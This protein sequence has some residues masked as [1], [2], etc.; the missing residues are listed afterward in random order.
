MKAKYLI[1]MLLIF[2]VSFAITASVNAKTIKVSG[3]ISKIDGKRAFIRYGKKWRKLRVNNKIYNGVEIKTG[4]N[5]RVIIKFLDNS[6]LRIAQKSKILIEK[7]FVKSPENRKITAKLL[8][9]KLWAKVTKS[10][11]KKRNFFVKTDNA[12]AGVRGT[13]FGV[14]LNGK[15]SIVSLYTGSID[16]TPA[17]KEKN[18]KIDM[19]NYDKRKRR[20]VSG[21]KEVSLKK[22]KQIVL[23]QMQ[24]VIISDNG[25]MELMDIIPEEEL[26][27]EWVA[28]NSKLDKELEK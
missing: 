14:S 24:R 3:V 28:W 7:A 4:K 2:S 19:R 26:K 21:P 10:K 1:F 16:V 11:F 9:G 15:N 13:S 6:E 12:T 27:D 20:E 22:W 17:K 25:D 5:T 8:L 18:K 23:K